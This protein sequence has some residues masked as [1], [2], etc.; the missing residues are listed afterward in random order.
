MPDTDT[1]SVCWF[2]EGWIDRVQRSV[3]IDDTLWT[4]GSYTVQANDLATLEVLSTLS[5]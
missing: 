1:V 3:V 4:T 5:L 2:Y